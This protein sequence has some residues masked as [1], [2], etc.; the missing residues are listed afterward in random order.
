[1]N[2]GKIVSGGV[3]MD[4]LRDVIDKEFDV[5]IKKESEPGKQIYA[6][7]PE[8][9][10]KLYKEAPSWMICGICPIL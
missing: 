9:Q 1:M 4:A 2:N 3:C 5:R 6:E 7:I 8:T 10:T